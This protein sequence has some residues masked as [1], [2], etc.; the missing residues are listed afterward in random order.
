MSESDEST[1]FNFL[2][3]NL[4]LWNDG[5]YCD[6]NSSDL[7]SSDFTS[8]F[9]T[10][11]NK[12]TA[13][14]HLPTKP[15]E[16]SDANG[17]SIFSNWVSNPSND[18]GQIK[19]SIWSTKPQTSDA[20]GSSPNWSN[21]HYLGATCSDEIWDSSHD[22]VLFGVHDF[23]SDISSW[24]HD[25]TKPVENLNEPP[26]SVDSNSTLKP[27]VS[28]ELD[29]QSVLDTEISSNLKELSLSSKNTCT[30]E[31]GT[32]NRN[33]GSAADRAVLS[34]D[35]LYERLINTNEGWG[36]KPIN[37]SIPW[38]T[39][40]AVKAIDQ[41]CRSGLTT[42]TP[43]ACSSAG[44]PNGCGVP[45]HLTTEDSNVWIHESPTGTGIWEMYYDT[46]RLS[47]LQHP[48]PPI[49]ETD[50]SNSLPNHITT[51]SRIVNLTSIG[52]SASRPNISGSDNEK[53]AQIWNTT[54][55]STE[56]DNILWPNV[57]TNLQELGGFLSV[58]HSGSVQKHAVV[59]SPHENIWN[60][61]Q[62]VIGRPV[63]GGA[64][65]SLI[66]SCS[67]NVSFNSHPHLTSS[68]ADGISGIV[69]WDL[70]PNASDATSW[71]A[72]CS[73]SNSST[74]LHTIQSTDDIRRQHY[75]LSCAISEQ[76]DR[77]FVHPY[78]NTYHA[79]LVK[80]LVNQGFKKEDV[81]AA[82]IDCNMDPR[83]ALQKLRDRY[84]YT[85]PLNNLTYPFGS[86]LVR[87]FGVT[88]VANV[89]NNDGFS[90]PLQPN[91]TTVSLGESQSVSF[92]PGNRIKQVGPTPLPGL[93]GSTQL[94]TLS[95]HPNSHLL[96]QQITHQGP[97]T[98]PLTVPVGVPTSTSTNGSLLGQ[99]PSTS[100]ANNGSIPNPACTLAGS[101][102]NTTYMSQNKLNRPC[103]GP[104]TFTSSSA[105]RSP[106]QLS[107]L[108]SIFELQ[109]KLQG[110]Q[111]QIIMYNNNP[112]MCSQP[113]YADVFT[114]LHNQMQQL[115]SQL[116]S[117]CTQYNIICADN[118]SSSQGPQLQN[119][120]AAHINE[121]DD[122]SFPT[123]GT[124]NISTPNQIDSFDK[125]NQLVPGIKLNT[126][127]RFS[128]PK[129]STS[130][131]S[132]A[133]SSNGVHSTSFN[134]RVGSGHSLLW[135]PP[136]DQPRPPMEH[137]LS[138]AKN[139]PAFPGP[140][141]SQGQWL[142]IQPL[143]NSLGISPSNLQNLLSTHY[144]LTSFYLI[145][146]LTCTALVRLQDTENAVQL[147]RNCGDRLSLQ[148]ITEREADAQL[149]QKY[150]NGLTENVTATNQFTSISEFNYI[151][152][153]W[154]GMDYLL[155]GVNSNI[156]GK[157]VT[158]NHGVP[159]SGIVVCGIK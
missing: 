104:K 19:P 26:N 150:L 89:P 33:G 124:W 77:L 60:N 1:Q 130:N 90:C 149:H 126:G 29:N 93:H 63:L 132:S 27:P 39:L 148:F 158:N 99:P 20:D 78:S 12:G 100:L 42:P 53:C 118:V 97:L 111:Q 122:G 16:S 22:P 145:N 151:Q 4:G 107:I 61:P 140:N 31:T 98:L 120:V 17:T 142:L 23:G 92:P 6:A 131:W 106:R 103:L 153:N 81:Q 34:I 48:N 115:K 58:N 156:S 112:T 8:A 114:E 133:W 30:A 37:Q 121:S 7:W 51:D 43:G 2:N 71:P 136:S 35:Q 119:G 28:S 64:R 82:L 159:R 18:R 127:V 117:K 32:C 36:S 138:I 128:F 50:L 3:F 41:V 123:I 25:N 11:Q 141:E 95:S 73:S 125:P 86:E 65:P 68:S 66:P 110:I 96:R 54:K 157:K 5:L 137:T 102:N 74:S 21:T 55:L 59:H 15:S 152:N 79:D 113:Q 70:S 44:P 109:E 88:N 101:A 108:N 83:R 147:M 84:G 116:R 72:S 139:I 155:G 146:P 9:T 52:L 57:A 105:K 134:Q 85:R 94:A 144:R 38:E 129:H 13:Q 80:Y 67:E 75:L 49:R 62:H 56:R 87:N 76:R 46:R 14:N 135:Q 40:D 24:N 143:R 69:P 45:F 154:G 91:L 10:F 47:L